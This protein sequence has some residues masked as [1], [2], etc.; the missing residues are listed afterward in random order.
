M[1][2]GKPGQ[3]QVFSGS[4]VAGVSGMKMSNLLIAATVFVFPSFA[5]ETAKKGEAIFQEICASCHGNDGRAQTDMGK[6]MQAADLSSSGVQQHSDSD[7]V[8][9]V[10]NGKG[11]MPPM[12]DKLSDDDIQSVVQHVRKLGG[13]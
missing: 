10:K 8:K 7:L 9:T 1:M 4:E 6:K 3:L 11:K 5:Q 12:G 2:R 13:K